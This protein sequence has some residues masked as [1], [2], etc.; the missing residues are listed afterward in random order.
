MTRSNPLP[1]QEGGVAKRPRSLPIPDS[2]NAGPAELSR[3]LEEHRD[4]MA[5]R[6]I[7]EIGSRSQS[8]EPSERA[9]LEE[10]V[11]LVTAMLA[12][13]LGAYREQV[14]RL[15][16]EAATLY[17]NLGAHRG[18]AAGEAV[19][20]FQI[21]REVVLRTLVLDPPGGMLDNLGLRELLQLNR[22]V[23][24]GVA[25]AS[26]GHTDTLFFNLFQGTGVTRKLSPPVLAEVGTQV[27]AIREEL[28]RLLAHAS[29]DPDPGAK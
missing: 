7:L 22:L 1:T 20:E 3:W 23:D 26:V 2:P 16:Q 5:E 11:H 15:F 17:G 29:G 13:G 6:W 19:E 12:P 24:V 21:L 9:L 25:Y 14:E 27:E 10:F 18:Q 28:G 4:S 8:L